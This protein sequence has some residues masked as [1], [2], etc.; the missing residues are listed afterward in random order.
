MTV[1]AAPLHMVS[2]LHLHTSIMASLCPRQSRGPLL[3]GINV[4]ALGCLSP[5]SSCPPLLFLL[6][7]SEADVLIRAAG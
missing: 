3:K 4:C 6:A 1:C 5:L 7:E 2:G